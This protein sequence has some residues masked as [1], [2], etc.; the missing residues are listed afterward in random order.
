[1]NIN[2]SWEPK[3]PIKE[4]QI[5]IITNGMNYKI[6]F[7]VENFAKFWKSFLLDSIDSI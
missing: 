6:Q 7:T 5:S 1:M 4:F 2:K 3:N